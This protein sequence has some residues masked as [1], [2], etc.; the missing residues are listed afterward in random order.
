MQHI[1]YIL[2]LNVA[3]LLNSLMSDFTHGKYADL[4]TMTTLLLPFQFGFLCFL[5]KFY[6]NIVD[7]QCSPVFVSGVQ[8]TGSVIHI[9]VSILFSYRLLQTIEYI[10][11]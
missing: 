9:H 7:L 6:W 11:L 2:I 10:S 8:Q 1:L 5:K 3:T 4:Q